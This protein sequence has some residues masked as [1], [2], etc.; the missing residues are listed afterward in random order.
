MLR[1]ANEKSPNECETIGPFL[2]P[3]CKHGL[4]GQSYE[5][6]EYVV[7]SEGWAA[8]TNT[9]YYTEEPVLTDGSSRLMSIFFC[10]TSATI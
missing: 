1:F 3:E 2:R 8:V 5:G 7:D 4:Y 9:L 6:L 10:A